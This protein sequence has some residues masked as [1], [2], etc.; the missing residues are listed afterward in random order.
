MQ[1]A[2]LS[3]LSSSLSKMTILMVAFTLFSP[4]CPAAFGQS[5]A[6]L[7][8][9]TAL[10]ARVVRLSH[11]QDPAKNGQ[12][13]ASV[14]AFPGG[15]AEEDIYSSTDGTAFAKISA[16][17]DPDFSG[18]LC[19]GTL[20]ELPSQVG[21]LVP[22]TLLWAGSVG[23]N[24][25]TQPMQL[26]IYQSADQGKTWTY[27]SNCAEATTPK[28]VG[29]GLWEPQFEIANDGALVCFYSDETQPG[30]SQLIH[31]VRSYDGINWQNSTFTVASTN[32]VDRPGMA[33]VTKLPSGTYFMTYE[34]CG[35]KACAVFS[36][37]SPDGWNWGDPANLGTKILTAAGQWF[38]HAP[39]NA[40]APSA[41]SK[42]GTILLVGQMMF[43]SSGTVSSGNGIT[44][45]TNHSSDG[46]GAWGTMPAPVRVPNAYNNYC[47]NYSSPLLPSLDGTSV[48]EFASQYV[49][50]TCTMFFATSPIIAGTLTPMLTIAPASQTIGVSQSLAVDVAVGGATG[51]TPTGSVTL[52]S[53]S[54][55]SAAFPLSN[56]SVSITI[57]G[58]S[59]P[60]GTD[61]LTA[62]YSG[63]ANYTSATGTV[64]VS[65]TASL[66]PSFAINGSSLSIPPGATTGN[67]STITV[68]PS[69]G[70]TGSV[71]LT[72]AILSSPADAKYPPTLSFGSTSPVNIT[73][74]NSGHATLIVSTS[75]AVSAL[76]HATGPIVSPYNVG[77]A[78]L[79][80]GVCFFLPKR[81]VGRLSGRLY[82]LSLAALLFVAIGGAGIFGC[83]GGGGGNATSGNA[84]TTSGSYLVQIAG[85]S[86]DISASST[87]T[88][89]VQ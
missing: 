38:E 81:R 79:S 67:T 10:Y 54:Y 87:F 7:S 16:I 43:D 66:N 23:Q 70:F 36:R 86:G 45:F 63:D 28:S 15:V 71:A 13:I 78:M 49:G 58:N 27:L 76:S 33:V 5:G 35:S 17:Q 51:Y 8:S 29:G 56:G 6:P 57:P 80:C 50:T 31:Q 65:V 88:L 59:L 2:C 62:T 20:F 3:R 68:T 1:I 83:G 12:I 18:G 42:S 44:I 53:G 26:K 40:W 25:T 19:C 64:S 37:T 4:R 46:S 32:S 14:T 69:G 41:T 11:N 22:G 61:T 77:I 89:T 30:H 73:S 34:I 72:A 39:T 74:S 82:V 47:P 52:S 24:S 84:G 75:A 9:A 60:A 55:T 48:L 21:S 85:V